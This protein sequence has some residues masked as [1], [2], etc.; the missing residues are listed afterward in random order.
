VPDPPVRWRL[1]H[2]TPWFDNQVATLAFNGQ[3]ADFALDKAVPDEG[4]DPR[5]ERVYDFALSTGP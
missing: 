2:D 1:T 5:I 3:S 4:R